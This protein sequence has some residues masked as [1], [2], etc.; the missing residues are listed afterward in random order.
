[1]A[2]AFDRG[3]INVGK[4]MENNFCILRF[5]VTSVSLSS[6]VSK[7]VAATCM[8]DP[9]GYHDSTISFACGLLHFFL[10]L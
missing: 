6:Y 4:V 2:G 9:G 5:A 3:Q 8:I 1:M 10:A 7:E